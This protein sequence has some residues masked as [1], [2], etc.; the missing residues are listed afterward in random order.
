MSDRTKSVTT[1]KVDMSGFQSL[2]TAVYRASTIVF[3]NA[4]AYTHR[5]E[6]GHQGYSYGLYGTPTTRTQEAKLTDLA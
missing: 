6:R 1:P 3:Y 4:E 2:G 5:G